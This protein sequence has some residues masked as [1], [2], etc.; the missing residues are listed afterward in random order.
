M[1]VTHST[2]WRALIIITIIAAAEFVSCSGSPAQ[3]VSRSYR[4]AMYMSVAGVSQELEIFPFDAKMFNIPLPFP[5]G[6][7]TYGPDGKALYATA[8]SLDPVNHFIPSLFKIEFNPTRAISIPGSEVLSFNSLAISSQKDKI[9]A[10]GA[11]RGT[12]CGIFELSVPTGNVREIAQISQCDPLNPLMYWSEVEVSP[13]GKRAIAL[14]NHE[15][16]LIDL[17][18]GKV[19]VMPNDF[20]L[21]AWSPDG[22][23]LAAVK[24]GSDKTFLLDARTLAQSRIIGSTELKWSPDSRYLL[25]I[26]HDFA[27]S[28]EI[29]TLEVVDIENGRRTEIASSRCRIDRSTLGWVS[30][31]IK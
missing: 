19:S 15:L 20:I 10:A 17:T 26:K 13:D 23:W 6:A 18:N 11:R 9:I 4:P 7:F 12:P 16:H 2:E 24:N 5:L 28:P 25:G 29:G 3:S 30:N 8:L 1:T 31:E 27:C 21:G 14:R 22:K